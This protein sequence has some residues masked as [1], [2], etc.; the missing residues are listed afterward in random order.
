MTNSDPFKKIGDLF[1]SQK[2]AVLATTNKSQPYCN[3]V[4]FA[5]TGDSKSLIF[6]TDRNTS[7]F[8]NLLNNRQV[9]L[10][11]DDRSNPSLGFGNNIAV[12]ALGL[13]EEISPEEKPYFIELLTSKHPDIVSFI[14]RSDNSLFRVRISDYIIAGF[15]SLEKVH[16]EESH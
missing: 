14:K 11:I 7:K 16:I 3:L 2:L 15:S 9:S 10:L 13:A 6:V 12:T 5:E 1:R 8:R 4:A